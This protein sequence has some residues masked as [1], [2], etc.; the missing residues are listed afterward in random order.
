MVA[1]RT[2]KGIS[3]SLRLQFPM[4]PFHLWKSSRDS[5]GGRK[6]MGCL[7]HSSL[8][9]PHEV[10]LMSYHTMRRASILKILP[11]Q[12]RPGHQFP[13]NSKSQD[14]SLSNS[15]RV[16]SAT[17]PSS[18][19]SGIAPERLGGGHQELQIWEQQGEPGLTRRATSWQ[20]LIP[21]PTAS[22]NKGWSGSDAI[23]WALLAGRKGP[24]STETVA[25]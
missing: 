5:L 16:D 23:L 18:F 11:L 20:R 13:K 22:R 7:L 12:T 24:I 2:S 25:P 19:I 8:T 1:W 10:T 15:L 4:C 9:C 14:Q 21:S 6:R 17:C 3:S